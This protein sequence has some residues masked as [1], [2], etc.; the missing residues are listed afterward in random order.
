LASI[1][2]DKLQQKYS[3]GVLEIR[4][5]IAPFKLERYYAEYE[6]SAKIMM[7]SSDC[8]S[9]TL[10]ELLAMALPESLNLWNNLRL[11][12]T[13][14]Q[15]HPLFRYEAAQIYEK[16][17]PENLMTAAPE[18]A[19]Y[20][21]MQTLLN[22]GDHVI[23]LS[24]A[25]QSLYEI[26]N[27]LGCQVTHWNLKAGINGWQLDIERLAAIISPQTRLLVI[28]FP[29]NPTGFLPTREEFDSIIAL[30][31]KN[32]TYIFSDEMYR[33]LEYETH[34]RLP[35]M[36]DA[37][38]RGISLSGL[39]KSLA[40]PGLRLGWLASQDSSLPA[41]WMAFKDYT[42]ICSSAPSEILGIIALQ[43]KETILARNLEII[44]TNLR[45]SDEFFANH[46][47]EFSWNRPKAGS[48]AFPQWK[49]NFS[50]EEFCQKVINQ[51]SVMLVPGNIF[52]Y[53]GNYFRLGLG[54][55]NFIDGIGFLNEFL[56]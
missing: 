28:N 46:L 51:F 43:N 47:D 23:V 44:K 33:L 9:L 41:K 52:E 19:I 16:I 21:A 31:R 36:C 8:E 18:E 15:G 12:Y 13:E 50:V 39:S 55:R 14:T 4:M 17:T 54:R 1:E 10:P 49:G 24:P 25:Y 42:T 35:C 11:G 5:T 37:Y 30:A 32:N 6:F 48:I 40:L 20:I 7:S 2:N 45:L 53:P 56:H 38:E 26:A 3:I 22:P 27:S 29:N 34:F